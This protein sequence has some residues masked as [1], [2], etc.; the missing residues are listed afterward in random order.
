VNTAQAAITQPSANTDNQTI[1][2]NGVN[3]MRVIPNS[4]ENNSAHLAFL[5]PPYDKAEYLVILATTGEPRTSIDWTSN[6][7]STD[8]INVD[9]VFP[10]N[11]VGHHPIHRIEDLPFILDTSAMCHI[12]P[13]ASDFKLLK[14]TPH[15]PVKGLCGSAIY[16]VGMGYIKLCIAGGHVLKL[17][18]VLYIPESSVCLISILAL[19]QSRNYTTH[20]DSS[21]C[22]VMNN[23][24]TTLVHS[25][26]SDSKRLYVLTTKMPSVQH[27]TSA[28]DSA[29]FTRMPDVTIRPFVHGG[30]YVMKG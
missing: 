28:V 2:F 10:V 17:T 12:S 11:H 27:T 20:F 15:R 13:E 21:G 8:N 16:A 18:D 19:N 1:T 3:Y 23:S 9:S 29:L 26:L 30:D 4:S 22:W 24:N 6:V 14:S 25:A 7:C 5:M